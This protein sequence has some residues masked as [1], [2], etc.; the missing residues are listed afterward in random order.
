L[1]CFVW[2]IITMCIR[3][4]STRR[5]LP[6]KKTGMGWIFYLWVCYWTKSYTHR[7]WWVRVRVYTTHTRIPAG[8]TYPQK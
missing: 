1:F 7:V 2:F 8:K 5:L 6:D 3:N 4:L